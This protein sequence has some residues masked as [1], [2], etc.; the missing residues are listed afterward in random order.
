[1]PSIRAALQTKLT[2]VCAVQ[3]DGSKRVQRPLPVHRPPGEESTQLF[4]PL[5][6]SPSFCLVVFRY[7]AYVVVV[8][9]RD[10]SAGFHQPGD[11]PR[12][13]LR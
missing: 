13:L 1:M 12:G 2:G 9:A 5:P 7:L 10:L 8:Q 11:G 3:V 6:P 4:P